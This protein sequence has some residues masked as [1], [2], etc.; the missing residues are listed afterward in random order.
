MLRTAARSLPTLLGVL[1]G[2]AL[3]AAVS[4]VILGAPSADAEAPQAVARWEYMVL[5][6]ARTDHDRTS[7]SHALGELGHS[8]WRLVDVDDGV[9]YLTRP[10]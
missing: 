10:R 6:T 7:A 1:V 2:V 4:A 3:S 9:F 8:G 5:D